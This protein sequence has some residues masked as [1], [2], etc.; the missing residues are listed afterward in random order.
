MIRILG[1]DS[2]RGLVIFLFSTASRTVLK[3]TQPPMQLVSGSLS[4]EVMRPERELTTHFPLV[5]RLRMR[6]AVPPLP[7][8]AFMAWYLVKQRENFTFT[9]ISTDE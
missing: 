9:L 4:L 3:P 1:F 2:R 5:P 7:Q 8:Y 6:G